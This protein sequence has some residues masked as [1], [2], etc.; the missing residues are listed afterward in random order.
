M[1]QCTVTEA[2]SGLS[3]I[4][5]LTLTIEEPVDCSAA[6]ITYSGSAPTDYQYGDN[7]SY[8]IGSVISIDLAVCSYVVT[9]VTPTTCNAGASADSTGSFDAAT[10]ILTLYTMNDVIFAP[11]SYP[12]TFEV[13][14]VDGNKLW[15]R[16][17]SLLI[18]SPCGNAN[19]ITI[20][21]I[22]D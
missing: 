6:V 14:D 18:G 19:A 21:A 9:C 22:S 13:H 3:A 5:T 12:I 15:D 11:G 7:W 2:A 17:I 10:S 4:L 16:T 20:D 8:D 1:V